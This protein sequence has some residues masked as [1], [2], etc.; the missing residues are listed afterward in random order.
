VGCQ[1]SKALSGKL[2]KSYSRIFPSQ[3][4]PA[5]KISQSIMKSIAEDKTL[6]STCHS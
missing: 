3:N 6:A 2:Q 5:E 4:V 1:N